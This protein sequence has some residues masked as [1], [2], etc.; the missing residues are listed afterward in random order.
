[1]TNTETSQTDPR[2]LNISYSSLLD[3]HACPRKFQLKKLNA[4]T[5]ALESAEESVTFAFGHVVGLGIQL[6]FEGYREEEIYW[7][8]YLH[9]APDLFASNEKQKKSFWLALAAV[10]QFLSLRTNG[11]LEE[12]ELVYVDGK[13]ATELSFCINLPGGY[14]YRGFVDAVLQSKTSGKVMVLECKTSSATN[15]NA[16]TYKNSSQAVGYSVV[17]DNLF[18]ELSSYEVLYLVY[19]TKSN[20]Y[21]S[22]PFTKSYLQRAL[23]IRELLLDV[24]VMSLYEKEGTYPMRGESCYQYFRECFYL[25]TCTLSTQ[26]LTTKLDEEGMAALEADK[27]A[28]QINVSISD[29]IESQMARG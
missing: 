9:W 14:R 22:L 10:Q 24:E 12:W 3:F 17:L 23:W 26:Y 18:P 19:S 8:L 1:M 5:E 7:K 21:E 27:A 28:Y 29:L 4:V 25:Q 11:F 15:L 13:P 16:A 2:L 6:H 20:S